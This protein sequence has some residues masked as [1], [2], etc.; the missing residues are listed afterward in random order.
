MG[1]SLMEMNEFRCRDFVELTQ[2]YF[3]TGKK[4]KVRDATQDD[5]DR[6]LS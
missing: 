1:F 3:D 2:I 6:L 5:I 4:D